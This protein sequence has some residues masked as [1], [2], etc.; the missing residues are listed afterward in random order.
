MYSQR[1]SRNQLQS[2]KMF[3][4]NFLTL[5]LIVTHLLANGMKWQNVGLAHADYVLSHQGRKLLL[6]QSL[7]LLWMR[8]MLS[9]C[10]TYSVYA[11]PVL[12]SS[13]GHAMPHSIRTSICC[14]RSCCIPYMHQGVV[15]QYLMECPGGALPEDSPAPELRTVPSSGSREA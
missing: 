9:C 14:R 8:Y 4:I 10:N 5:Q 6:M 1:M 2:G 12:P 3:I 15:R 7:R 13:T 11:H